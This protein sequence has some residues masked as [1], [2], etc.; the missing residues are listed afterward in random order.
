MLR[1]LKGFTSYILRAKNSD[2]EVVWEGDVFAK[3]ENGKLQVSANPTD[4]Q[5]LVQQ[6]GALFLE[7]ERAWEVIEDKTDRD[8]TKKESII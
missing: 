6:H 8:E 4:F 2:G 7:W 3:E 1:E 5:Q